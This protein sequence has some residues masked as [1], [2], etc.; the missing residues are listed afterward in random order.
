M[1]SKF[2]NNLGPFSLKMLAEIAEAK[3]IAPKGQDMQEGPEIDI[4]GVKTLSE[5]TGK[6]ISFFSNKK[7]LEQ[8][9]QTQAKACV[10]PD[11]AKVYAPS[12]CW[13]LVSHNPYYSHAKIMQAF[14]QIVISY[15]NIHP[16]ACVSPSAQ[17]GKNCVIG[18]NVVIEDEVVIGDN[19]IIHAG[20]VIL[21]ACHIG[22]NANI[23]SNAVISHADIGNDF[24]ALNGVCIGQAGFG[25]A[26]E[27]GKHYEVPQIGQVIIGND[28]E[29]GA[30]SC[31]DRGSSENTVIGDGCRIDNLVQIGHNVKLGKGCIIVAQVGIAGSTKLGDYVALGGQVGVSGHLK[32][33]N[34]AQV[35]AQS[36]VI[37]DVVAGEILGGTPA[38]NVRDWHKQTIAL[39]KLIQTK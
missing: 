11:W 29:I 34:Q 5:A 38:I 33:G 13:L 17:I 8:F 9:K 30:G 31:I 1:N 36:G 32:I 27:K 21:R 25:F 37:K 20:A 19:A 7:Y 39:K 28:V 24:R 6:D 23:G 35:S 4:Y 22:D 18:P 26:T 16:K 3:L 14:Y 12:D 15:S 2:F 10:I